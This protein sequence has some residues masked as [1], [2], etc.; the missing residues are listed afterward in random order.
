MVYGQIGV[1]RLFGL[2]W[3]LS[4]LIFAWVAEGRGRVSARRPTCFL[5]LRQKK[6][7]KEKA[8]LLAATPSL[9]FGATWVGALAGWAAELT[10][11]LRSFVRTT[12]AS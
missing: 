9:R 12:A 1:W 8:T 7:G 3:Q 5:L 4:F 6:V 11:L 10:S 2:R